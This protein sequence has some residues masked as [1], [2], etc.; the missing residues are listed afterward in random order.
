MRIRVWRTLMIGRLLQER[1]QWATFARQRAEHLRNT[2]VQ[3]PESRTFHDGGA[4]AL[5]SLAN[6]LMHAPTPV[7]EVVRPETAARRPERLTPDTLIAGIPMDLDQQEE[8]FL[9][10]NAKLTL[11]MSSSQAQRAMQQFQS[12]E[13]LA[14]R[15][16]LEEKF[17]QLIGRKIGSDPGNRR[18]KIA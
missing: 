14:Q 1:E 15:R 13:K 4:S 11:G 9:E 8:Q 6:E 7:I 2:Q 12:E 5:E 3:N 18:G 10:E 16:D 17:P